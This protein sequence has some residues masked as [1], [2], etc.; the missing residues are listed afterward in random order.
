MV[1][2]AKSCFHL[3]MQE[4]QHSYSFCR[5]SAAAIPE[6]QRGRRVKILWQEPAAEIIDI[7]QLD[8]KN[9]LEP[10]CNEPRALIAASHFAGNNQ[11]PGA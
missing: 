8:F 10:D 5:R 11:R 1:H 3:V 2:L 9:L 7:R 6:P 4:A